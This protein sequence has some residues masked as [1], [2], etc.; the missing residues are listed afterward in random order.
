MVRRHR[1]AGWAVALLAVLVVV[2]G[3]AAVEGRGAALSLCYDSEISATHAGLLWE[4]ANGGADRVS[5]VVE[6]SQRDVTASSLHRSETTPTDEV[7]RAA[8]RDAHALGLK[9]L[10]FPIVALDARAAGDWR[11]VLRPASPPEWFASYGQYVAHYARIAAE[12]DAESFSVGSELGSLEHR[13]AEWRTLIADVREIY[14]GELTYSANWD[15][16]FNTPFWDDLD[17][18][19][20]TAYYELADG[21][22][23]PSV[24]VMTERFGQF[25][26]AVS[27]FSEGV[28][29]PV[30]V[31]EAGYV[32]QPSAAARPW[33]H[34]SDG[35]VDLALQSACWEAFVRSLADVR[36]VRAAYVWNWFGGGG[37]TDNGYTVRGKPA[38]AA[39]EA[40]WRGEEGAR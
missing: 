16:Y 28:G 10:L 36:G 11:G 19:G 40:W 9:V 7:V 5:L 38:A 25:W 3:Y 17:V 24:E 2:P 21:A 34:T 33:D 29:R 22:E 20:I 31:T 39:V 37:P 18:A 30:M 26:E 4:I 32:S 14:G 13:D 6:W 35:D 8:I 15:H 23:R 12:E 27:V 1:S